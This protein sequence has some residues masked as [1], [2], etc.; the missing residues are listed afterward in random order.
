MVEAAGVEPACLIDASQVIDNTNRQFRQTRPIRH[1]EVH[2]GYTGPRVPPVE[3]F[4]DRASPRVVLWHE[5][6]SDRGP[7]VRNAPLYLFPEMAPAPDAMAGKITSNEARRQKE[8]ALARLRQLEVAEREG[9]VIQTAAVRTAWSEHHARI[10]DR[11]LSIPDRLSEALAN[12]PA[13]VVREKLTAEIEDALRNIADS[14][15]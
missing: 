8:V 6:A 4:F 15:L 10:R 14:V 3:G 9:E 13:G 2:G 7:K 11:F 12:Q 5:F 1:S